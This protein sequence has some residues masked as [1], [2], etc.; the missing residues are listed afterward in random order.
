MSLI[1]A[2]AQRK[3]YNEDIVLAGENVISSPCLVYSITV[4]NDSDTAAIVN[5]S[6]STSYDSNSRCQKVAIGAAST[7]HL[8]FPRG[9][10]LS[11]GLSVASNAGSIDISATYD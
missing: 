6:D 3:V 8:V 9:L 5:M 2:S 10:P 1:L 4:V 11:A 7:V